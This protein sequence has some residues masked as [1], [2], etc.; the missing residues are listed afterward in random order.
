MRYLSVMIYVLRIL[1][2]LSGAFWYGSL[3]FIMRF[4]MPSIRAAGAAGGP[5]MA[6]LNQ[7]KLS[8]AMMGAAIV[9]V[10]AG[11]WLM[12]IV[13]GGNPG[14]WMRSGMGRTFALGGAF[15]ILALIVG[16]VV[17]APVTRRMGTLAATIG[18]RGA[19]PTP[20]EL[21]EMGRLQQR[22]AVGT[23]IIAVLLTLAVVA[24]AVARYV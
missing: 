24:M 14:P 19:P 10:G 1:H 23:A 5:V 3:I 12:F 20:E 16:M 15:A 9:N 7:R 8:L 17:V 22:N 21:A 13:S 4:L 18:R 11:I 2:I 6:Q